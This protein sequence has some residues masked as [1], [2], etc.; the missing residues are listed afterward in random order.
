MAIGHRG[1]FFLFRT[2]FSVPLF[3]GL[4]AVGDQYPEHAADAAAIPG[5]HIAELFQQLI[6]DEKARVCL[7]GIH[8]INIYLTPI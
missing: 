2:D 7:F 5:G 1:G 4:H 6:G 3:K 8:N